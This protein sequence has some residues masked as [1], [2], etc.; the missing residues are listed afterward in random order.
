M[1]QMTTYNSPQMM[2][3][4]NNLI[5]IVTYNEIKEGDT[6]TFRNERWIDESVV[7]T[8]MKEIRPSMGVFG[9]FKIPTFYSFLYL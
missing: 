4:V 2:K 6:V 5:D 3:R 1:E 9:D 7:V 8:E